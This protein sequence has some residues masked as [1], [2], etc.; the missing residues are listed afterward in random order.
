MP[1]KPTWIGVGIELLYPITVTSLKDMLGDILASNIKIVLL[2]IYLK[3]FRIKIFLMYQTNTLTLQTMVK[4][5]SR[6]PRI[7]YVKRKIL[8]NESPRIIQT[9]PS[10]W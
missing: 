4:S 5:W 9:L 2:R 1:S 6:R 7:R 10:L 3:S 8:L